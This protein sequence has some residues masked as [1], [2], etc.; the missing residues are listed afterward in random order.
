MGGALG[1]YRG[2]KVTA[3][4]ELGLVSVFLAWSVS[5]FHRDGH[6]H[7]ESFT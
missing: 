1:H 5:P 4:R 7:P 3:Q 2:P 6:L